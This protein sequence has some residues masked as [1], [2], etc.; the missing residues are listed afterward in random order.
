M[1]EDDGIPAAEFDEPFLPDGSS[2]GPLPHKQE[3]PDSTR[4]Q[5]FPPSS[6]GPPTQPPPSNPGVSP[7]QR[8][9]ILLE[10]LSVLL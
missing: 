8:A 10:L 1:Q 2:A 4:Y 5:A 3:P 7:V 6:S 9:L